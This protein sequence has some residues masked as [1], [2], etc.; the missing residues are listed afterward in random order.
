MSA[1]EIARRTRAWLVDAGRLLLEMLQSIGRT[2]GRAA[3]GLRPYFARLTAWLKP[4]LA[5]AWAW[6]KP[7]VAG[8]WA[9]LRPRVSGAW[10][11]LAPRVR[12]SIAVSVDRARRGASWS[13][14]TAVRV[15]HAFLSIARRARR[16]LLLTVRTLLLAALI[17]GALLG[18]GRA[19]VQHV[20]PGTLAVRHVRWGGA[21]VIERDYGPGLHWTVGLRDTW[22]ELSAGTHVLSF[23]SPAE[24]GTH[25][26]LEVATREGE[27]AQVSVFVPYRIQSG[28]GWRLV[29]DG[30][31]ADYPVRALAICRRVLLEEL[32]AL[33]P[34]EFADPDARANIEQAALARLA[35]ELGATHL[36][37]L[38]VRIGS[39]FFNPTYEKKMLEKQLA[40]QGVLTTESLTQR[41][42]EQRENTRV[43]QELEDAEAALVAQ[44]EQRADTLR[45][46]HKASVQ[47]T[48]RGATH[49]ANRRRSETE[50]AVLRLQNEG[51]LA[52]AAAADLRQTL[53]DDALE[54]SGGK[55]HVARQA[56]ENLRFGKVTLNSNDPRV[57]SVLDLDE[58]VGLLMGK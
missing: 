36:E 37:P 33:S 22:H 53:F 16:P 15:G 50:I 51:E 39:V 24:G 49:Y 31:R 11:W 13:R 10:A 23:G 35:A 38:E 6:L 44:Y 28:A 18:A 29:A 19:F 55:L 3:G 9:W 30:L 42:R 5:G 56:A 25:P 4:R 7:R 14:R 17:G 48:A 46:A 47:T 58:L 32:A 2:L 40:T 8:A 26:P 45:D 12:R 1:R 57:P 27:G 21:G 54:S 43:L 52:L 41:L 20:P 34:S